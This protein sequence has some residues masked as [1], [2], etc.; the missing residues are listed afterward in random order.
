MLTTPYLIS[1]R[2]LQWSSTSPPPAQPVRQ[3]HPRSHQSA[4]DQPTRTTTEIVH[5]DL[6]LERR[7]EQLD[8]LG[9]T[10]RGI[11]RGYPLWNGV[12]IETKGPAVTLSDSRPFCL[13]AYI[14]CGNLA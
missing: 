2:R 4:P 13:P 14:L 12:S 7:S 9:A 10:P 1:T 11:P 8:K 5:T 3:D 6:G